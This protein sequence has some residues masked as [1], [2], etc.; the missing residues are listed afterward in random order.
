[1]RAEAAAD[2][3]VREYKKWRLAQIDEQLAVCHPCWPGEVEYL[4]DE[5]KLIDSYRSNYA[6]DGWNFIDWVTYMMLIASLISHFVDIGVQSV[7]TA[8]WHARIVSMTII[9]V[10]M[11][12]LKS[13]RAYL[14]L[15]PFIVI[16]GKLILVIGR[17]IFL[18]LTFFIPYTTEN[19]R[20]R[21][22]DELRFDEV[23]MTHLVD[24]SG[25]PTVPGA[26]VRMFVF[27]VPAAG[28]EGYDWL[29]EGR[30]SPKQY[31][32]NLLAFPVVPPRCYYDLADFGLNMLLIDPV[33]SEIALSFWIATSMIVLLNLLIAMLTDAFQKVSDEALSNAKMQQA[34]TIIH[35]MEEMS[36]KRLRRFYDYLEGECNPYVQDYDDDENDPTKDEDIVKQTVVDILVMRTHAD[37]TVKA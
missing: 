16:L 2:E 3:A 5:K 33:M 6:S 11:R 10:W 31:C 1:M 4:E 27:L 29:N 15:G 12:I 21:G 26:S 23:L 35:L 18:Y 14:D 8:R 30:I 25:G 36:E 13:V 28:G 22:T 32:I 19:D 24:P 20:W 37:R 9:L 34:I 7:V 17:F